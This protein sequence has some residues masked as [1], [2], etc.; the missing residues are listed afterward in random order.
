MLAVTV[1]K[2]GD[3]CER[4]SPFFC[5]GKAKQNLFSWVF[6]TPHLPSLGSRRGG[7]KALLKPSPRGLCL[8]APQP[9]LQRWGLGPAICGRLPQAT[10]EAG[11]RSRT[12]ASH[13]FNCAERTPFSVRDKFLSEYPSVDHTSPLLKS[14]LQILW[15]FR[16]V[17]H[18][19]FLCEKRGNHFPYEDEWVS[20]CKDQQIEAGSLLE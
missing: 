18:L 16:Y 13:A 20:K 1:C 6:G 3:H 10:K 17:R 5:L 11:T 2:S 8:A 9:G 12:C 14:D 19:V 7:V 15:W 4:F